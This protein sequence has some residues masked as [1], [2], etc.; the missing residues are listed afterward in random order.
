MDIDN[1]V[2]ADLSILFVVFSKYF[3]DVFYTID[4]ENDISD[5]SLSLYLSVYTSVFRVQQ[6]EEMKK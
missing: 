4:A 3:V 6:F 1:G 2:Q 5:R